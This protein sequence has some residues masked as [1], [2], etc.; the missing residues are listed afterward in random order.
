VQSARFDS[1]SSYI[2]SGLIINTDKYLEHSR[3]CIRCLYAKRDFLY[4]SGNWRGVAQ[5]RVFK[6]SLSTASNILV[7][8]HSDYKTNF[9]Q[10]FPLFLSG[11]KEMWG[12]NV[13][14][15][16]TKLQSL[17]LGL[18]NP[19]DES[20][21][22]QIFGNVDH[23]RRATNSSDIPQN[24]NNSTYANF[25]INTSARNRYKLAAYLN[26]LGVKLANIDLSE[27][28]RIAYLRELRRNNFVVCPQ[29]N[30][31]DTHRLW[32]TLYMGGTPV[33]LSSKHMNHLVENLPVIVLKSWR[34]LSDTQFMEENWHKLNERKFNYENLNVNYWINKFCPVD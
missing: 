32:E 2:D 9:L 24:F 17:P 28:G 18:T 3:K 23:L 25:S 21:L 10:V 6:P 30:G 31:P 19:S 12:T 16:G 27:I 13:S 33:I 26:T 29:G 22:H 8:G 7:F 34:Q 20:Q 5:S 4:T 1:V 14:P 11:Y 15:F